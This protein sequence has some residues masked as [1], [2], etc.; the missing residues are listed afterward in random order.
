VVL[1]PRKPADIYSFGI[2]LYEMVTSNRQYR[3][4]PLPDVCLK[5]ADQNIR[6]KLPPQVKLE[7]KNLIRR[8]WHE[9]AEKRPTVAEVI[10]SLRVLL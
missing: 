10:D 6:P 1:K 8:C 5:F 4:L 2:I 7:V 9:S 3:L